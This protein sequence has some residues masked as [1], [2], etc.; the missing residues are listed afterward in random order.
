MTGLYQT[1]GHAWNRLEGLVEGYGLE[2]FGYL[3]GR[4]GPDNANKAGWID[5]SYGDDSGGL[6]VAIDY[7]WDDSDTK[8][9]DVTRLYDASDWLEVLYLW[10]AEKT[11]SRPQKSCIYLIPHGPMDFVDEAVVAPAKALWDRLHREQLAW[12]EDVS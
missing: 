1:A 12:S 4:P 9:Y 5:F 7:R 3:G 2:L 6:G 11:F 8:S 10:G